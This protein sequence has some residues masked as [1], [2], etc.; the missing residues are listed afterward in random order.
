MDIYSSFVQECKDA[1]E[2][3]WDTLLWRRAGGHSP[4]CIVDGFVYNYTK[5]R[6]LQT[7]LFTRMMLANTLVY[8]EKFQTTFFT[9]FK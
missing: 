3:G 2:N 9:R 7:H 5:R 6:N 1:F 4:S 8:K